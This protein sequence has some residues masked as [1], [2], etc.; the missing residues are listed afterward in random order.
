MIRAR[1]V[2]H[3]DMKLE[4]RIRGRRSHPTRKLIA[5]R[6]SV[7]DT[8]KTFPGIDFNSIVSDNRRCTSELAPLRDVCAEEIVHADQRDDAAAA[9]DTFD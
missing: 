2:K 6:G 1:N 8:F 5:P 3:E 9:F 7:G 4:K